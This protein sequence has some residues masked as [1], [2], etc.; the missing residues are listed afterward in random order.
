MNINEYKFIVV[1]DIFPHHMLG[2]FDFRR[3]VSLITFS[4]QQP[5]CA[6]ASEKR[7]VSCGRR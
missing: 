3:I 1:R 4:F 6:T 7:L 2:R 5:F